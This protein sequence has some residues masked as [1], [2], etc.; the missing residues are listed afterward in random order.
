MK[1][2]E[3]LKNRYYKSQQH[4]YQ[5]YE[6]KIAF[7][8]RDNDVLL[9][10]GCGRTAPVLRK[11]SGKAGK[12]IGVDLEEHDA[13][14]PGVEYIKSDIGNISTVS[15]S[16]VDLVIS[17]AVLEHVENPDAVFAEINRVLKP[18]GNFVFL[19]PNLYD[20]ASIL[21][22]LIPN[23]YHGWIVSKTEGRKT[24]DVFPAYYRAN[25][26]SAINKLT[27]RTG[28]QIMDF[29]HV[30]QYPS[31]FMFNSLL[32]LLA[33]AYEKITSKF[34]FLRFLRGWLLIHIQKD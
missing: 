8:L 24:E 20:Y 7:V 12:L 10:A 3:K 23:R 5:L 34:E 9:D 18:G 31:Y 27:Q 30:G 21:S 14:L 17:R 6:Q 32:F 1:T 26:Y 4:P 11:F 2:T 15:D 29:Q 25:T 22:L 16:S 28:F 13:E 19:V 33:T